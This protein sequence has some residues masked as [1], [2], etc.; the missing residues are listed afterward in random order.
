MIAK[1]ENDNALLRKTK[2]YSF[3]FF[4]LL[5]LLVP[6]FALNPLLSLLYTIL[7]ITFFYTL[8]FF[9][10]KKQANFNCI[11]CGLCCTLKVTPTEKDIR[12]IEKGTGKTRGQFL[13]EG[14]LKRVNGYCLF[15][16]Q[17]GQNKICSI[18]QHRPSLCRQWP[19][20]GKSR[21]FWKWFL[22]CPSLRNL[23]RR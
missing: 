16:K 6:L 23:F 19:F 1:E 14:R 2:I 3:L 17:E 18:Y 9:A 8:G 7:F 15:L 11:T 12:R 5:F 22:L 4:S 21:V 10:Y 13:E 20:H